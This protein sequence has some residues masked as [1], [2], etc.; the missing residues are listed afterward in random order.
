MTEPFS[1]WETSIDY[2]IVHRDNLA[3]LPLAGA[4]IDK[5]GSRGSDGL[6]TWSVAR[7]PH[8]IRLRTTAPVANLNTLDNAYADDLRQIAL[9]LET[10]N[11]MIVPGGMHPLMDPFRDQVTDKPKNDKEK[12]FW[13]LFQCAGHAWVNQCPT[14]LTLPFAD[15]EAFG[16]LHAA[17]RIV[18][19]IIPALC[20]SS[21]MVEGRCNGI[22]DNRLRYLRTRCMN[23]Q[24][25]TGKMIPEPV[26]SEKKYK[27]Q[28]HGS[29]A[30]ELIGT[31]AEGAIDPA[32]LNNRAAV[33]RFDRKA[34]EIRI[35]EPQ[36]CP[37]AEMAIIKLVTELIK[38][39][40]EEKFI[41]FEEQTEARMEI[42]CGVLGDTIEQG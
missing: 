23:L 20:A 29:I 16:R 5:N 39:L 21:P 12:L 35:L 17:V 30:R 37:A 18:L 2:Q 24:A 25:V 15:D 13:E 31:A 40:T 4:M 1:S 41:S 34:M 38:A 22:R 27:D 36:E 14:K 33:P 19:P 10:F 28:I 9:T 26:F 7:Q 11:A 3:V 42:L 6:L 32:E 8:V